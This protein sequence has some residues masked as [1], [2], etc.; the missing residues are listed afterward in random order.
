MTTASTPSTTAR[1]RVL[2]AAYGLFVANGFSA[3]SMQ[4]I[5]D[6]AGITKATL[7][8]HF[9]DKHSLYMACMQRA[10]ESTQTAITAHLGQNHDLRTAVSSLVSHLFGYESGDLQRLAGDFKLHFDP[11]VQ[12]EFWHEFHPPW[13]LI[14]DPVQAAIDRGELISSDAMFIARYIYGAT[15]GLSHL[16]RLE[17]SG[18]PIDPQLIENIID[19]MLL[20]II[21]Q[22]ASN[23]VD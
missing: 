13:R 10:M 20:G 21:R 18:Q 4:Q 19:T 1:D 8:H 9:R 2:N 22:D 15:A 5:A 7:Y 11:A 12:R 17:Y 6:E 3:V 16:Y 14:S 23:P